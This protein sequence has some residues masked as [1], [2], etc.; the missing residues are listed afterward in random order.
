MLL[1]AL[2]TGLNLGLLSASLGIFTSLDSTVKAECP[3]LAFYHDNLIL[4]SHFHS[5]LNTQSS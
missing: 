2:N 5:E 4:P 1:N 3:G